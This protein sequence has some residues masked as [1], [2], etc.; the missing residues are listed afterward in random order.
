MNA[1]AQL[2]IKSA[3]MPASIETRWEFI[4]LMQVFNAFFKSVM[5]NS[6][7]VVLA[8]SVLMTLA[9]ST[10]FASAATDLTTVVMNALISTNVNHVS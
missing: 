5:S 3:T 2:A 6:T 1:N 7:F 10:V 8:V 9:R 4:I